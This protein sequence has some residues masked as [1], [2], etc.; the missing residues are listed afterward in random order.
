MD[1]A[2]SLEGVILSRCL[3]KESSYVGILKNSFKIVKLETKSLK[4][5]PLCF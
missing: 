5:S 2:L 4:I 3:N 1:L